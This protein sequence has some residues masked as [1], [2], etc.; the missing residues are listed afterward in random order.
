MDSPHELLRGSRVHRRR[1]GAAAASW[2][3]GRSTGSCARCSGAPTKAVA[4]SAAR[5]R[6]AITASV[7]VD[8]ADSTMRAA[9]TL[10]EGE[11]ADFALRWAP[12]EASER[13]AHPGRRGRGSDRRHRRGVALVGGGARHLRRPA[14]RPRAAQLARAPGPHLPARPARSSPRPPRRFPR[15]R[16]ASATG[17]TASRGSGTR[18]S[19][20]RP[21]TSARARTR[22]RTSSPS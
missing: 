1:G 3:R 6:S 2:R 15:T 11:R 22:P 10:S 21:C 5:A 8:I 19:R 4:R 7:P 13:R 12:V 18:A 9:F 17:T 14:P 20:S 16:A